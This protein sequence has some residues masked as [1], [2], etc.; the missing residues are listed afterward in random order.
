MAYGNLLQI[1]GAHNANATA[2]KAWKVIPELLVQHAINCMFS[3]KC[4][5]KKENIALSTVPSTV[6]PAPSLRIDLPYAIA[7]RKIF[8]G[9]RFRAQ[10][11][12][13]YITSDMREAI[14]NHTLNVL[15][16]RLT[17]CDIQSTITPDEGRHVPWHQY[18]I[19]AVETAKQTLISLDGITRYLKLE[20][21]ELNKK[22]REI[23]ER[24]VL[25]LE[26][27]KEIGYLKALEKGY[28]VDSGYYP[29]RE[30]DG[31]VRKIDKG[32]GVGTVVERNPDYFAPVCAHFG[33]NNL[34][35]KVEKPCD[36]IGGCTFCDPE[37][38][39]YI[40]EL[41]AED[42]VE[43]RL[44][45]I[46]EIKEKNLIKPEVEWTGDGYILLSMF[47]PE[48]LKIAESAGLLIAKKLGL[49]EPEIVHKKVLH[50]AEGTFLEIKA[51]VP[52]F[53]KLEKRLKNLEE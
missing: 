31:I 42:N 14:V 29:E 22:V 8:K 32:I 25:F 46:R 39:I 48:S 30:G 3:L 35:E 11:N 9:F 38:I 5:M 1:D 23:I 33:R 47:I 27:I 26:E 51:K 12:T 49:E 18:S 21:E 50:P 4:G 10:M 41:D 2:K 16:S 34:P 17:S 28:F 6:A 20:S 53:I 37:K 45:R 7:L 43:K 52:F 44:E 40:E 36:L 19:Y 24:A 13:R 15:I